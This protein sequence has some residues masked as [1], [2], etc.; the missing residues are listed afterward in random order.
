MQS[1][2]DM[3]KEHSTMHS[4]QIHYGFCDEQAQAEVSEQMVN[5]QQRHCKV[6]TRAFRG[7]Q[8]KLQL[9]SQEWICE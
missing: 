9:L 6:S 1:E 4:E 3:S 5:V 8:V 2:T 7:Q